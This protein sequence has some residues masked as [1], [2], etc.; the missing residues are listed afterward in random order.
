M[1]KAIV[2]LV[3]IVLI[4]LGGA[5]FYFTHSP[6]GKENTTINT[7]ITKEVE[8][9]S[10]TVLVSDDFKFEKIENDKDLVY[11]IFADLSS[12][13]KYEVPFINIKSEDVARINAEIEDSYT[14][15]VN[16][17]INSDEEPESFDFKKIEFNTYLYNKILSVVIYSENNT[18]NTHYSVYN[19]DITTGDEVDNE[20][21]LELKEIDEDTLLEA[22]KEAY[23]KKFEELYSEYNGQDVYDKQLSKTIASDNYSVDVPMYLNDLGELDVIGDIYSMA[24]APYN[25]Q[26]VHTNL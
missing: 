4:V 9:D 24:G 6:E 15:S 10:N 19:I 8:S 11:N 12:E 23:Q 5:F 21:I 14:N 3:I 18:D 16:E 2:V 22:L 1:K 7:N 20:T 17:L 13:Y 25:E 26:I